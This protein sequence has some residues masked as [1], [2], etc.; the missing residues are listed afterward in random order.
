MT[1]TELEALASLLRANGYPEDRP[2]LFSDWSRRSFPV[3]DIERPV[4]RIVY[5]S[6]LGTEDKIFYIPLDTAQ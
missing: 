1:L 5:A 2:I 6:H 4:E 3:L